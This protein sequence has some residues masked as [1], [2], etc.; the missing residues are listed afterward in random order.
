MNRHDLDPQQQCVEILL[1]AGCQND[2]PIGHKV[3]SCA[4]LCGNRGMLSQRLENILETA[5]SS[6][7]DFVHCIESLLLDGSDYSRGETASA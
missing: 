7:D 4:V 5:R 1:S 2:W 6:E 3:F